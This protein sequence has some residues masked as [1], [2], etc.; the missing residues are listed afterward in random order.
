MSARSRV[1][2]DEEDCAFQMHSDAPKEFSSV[3]KINVRFQSSAGHQITVRSKIV[4]RVE[5]MVAS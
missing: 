5:Y 1:N 2:I 4:S 3:A